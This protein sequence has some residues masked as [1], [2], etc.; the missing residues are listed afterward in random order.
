M[1]SKVITVTNLAADRIKESLS[2]HGGIG[3]LISIERG[4]SCSSS[5]DYSLS[6]VTTAGDNMVAIEAKGIKFFYEPEI[7]LM[8]RGL[9]IDVANGDEECGFVVTNKYHKPCQNC[10]C[11]CGGKF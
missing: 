9:D 4:D 3:L 1:V 2:E 11:R 7:E 5:L 10:S 8:I 6:Y